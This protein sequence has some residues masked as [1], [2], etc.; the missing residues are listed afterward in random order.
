M[1][2]INRRLATLFNTCDTYYLDSCR[3][4]EQRT[5]GGLGE[6]Q[7]ETYAPKPFSKGG[8]KYKRSYRDVEGKETRGK[9]PSRHN[10]V[11]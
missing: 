11:L 5:A 4:V 6:T 10:P 8:Y 3:K 1:L 7:R 9:N 2:Y